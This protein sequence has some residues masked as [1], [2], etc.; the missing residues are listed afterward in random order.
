MAA[1]P[2]TTRPATATGPAWV[3]PTRTDS[4]PPAAPASGRSDRS[5]GG[6][7]IIG[8]P[9]TAMPTAGAMV[10]DSVTGSKV[11]SISSRITSSGCSGASV[12]SPFL[13]APASATGSAS[14]AARA[15]V[16]A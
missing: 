13:A 9:A 10:T 3:S 8:P 7:V 16:T 14:F 5:S 12:L 11:A 1:A 4:P 6:R 2:L 15:A